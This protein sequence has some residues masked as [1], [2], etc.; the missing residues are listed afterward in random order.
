MAVLLAILT[1]LAPPIVHGLGLGHG[2]VLWL[3]PILALQVVL[4]ALHRKSFWLCAWPLATAAAVL[5]ATMLEAD[6]RVAALAMA[7]ISHAALFGTL[8]L[9]LGASLRAGQT[10]L[11]TQLAQRIDPN[12]RPA[13]ASYTRAIAIAWTAFF[14]GQCV[15]SGVLVLTAPR[16]VWSLFVNVLDLPLVAAMFVAEYA[17]RRHRFP[18]HPHVGLLAAVRAVRDGRMW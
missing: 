12:W 13:M 1:G 7:G 15:M 10:D 9:G 18:D 16:D 3:L 2:D 17:V 8:A 5:G 11:I 4:L 6:G 14:L